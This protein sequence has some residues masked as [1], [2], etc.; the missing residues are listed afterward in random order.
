M[1]VDKLYDS[2]SIGFLISTNGTESSMRFLKAQWSEKIPPGYAIEQA[3]IEKPS[4]EDPCSCHFT[5]TK[6]NN[7]LEDLTLR[8]QWYIGGKTPTNFVP[9]EGATDEVS[10]HFCQP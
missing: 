2:V 1:D 5:F 6:H 8:Y 7:E 3:L 9:I 10:L 4:E